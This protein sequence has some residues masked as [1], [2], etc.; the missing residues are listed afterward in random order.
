MG[1]APVRDAAFLADEG[2]PRRLPSTVS[3]LE[4]AGPLRTSAA[5]ERF[6]ADVE[7]ASQLWRAAYESPARATPLPLGYHPTFSSTE[8]H[9]VAAAPACTRD[10]ATGL[11]RPSTATTTTQQASYGRPAPT[12]SARASQPRTQ[13]RGS[14]DAAASPEQ[15][16]LSAVVP[17]GAL[18]AATGAHAGGA[19]TRPQSPNFGKVSALNSFFTGPRG[20]TNGG[21]LRR[22]GS[23]LA[24]SH[25]SFDSR[26]H[27]E[28]FFQVRH[29]DPDYDRLRKP[30]H[31]LRITPSNQNMGYL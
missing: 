12:L 15:P 30:S 18:A 10:P 13:Q 6:A 28:K 27:T 1:N 7:N 24:H 20:S 9:H 25:D 11:P 22:D 17:Q 29:A 19:C 2:I 26:F 31:F 23:S 8:R 3:S 5:P 14:G 4:H 16:H 21:G